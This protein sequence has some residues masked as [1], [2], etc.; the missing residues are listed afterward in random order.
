MRVSVSGGAECIANLPGRKLG[1]QPGKPFHIGTRNV[2]GSAALVKMTP[3]D[4]YRCDARHPLW[5]V[6][7]AASSSGARPIMHDFDVAGIITG[8]HPWFTDVFN[9]AFAPSKS[10]DETEVIAQVQRTRT[11]FGRPELDAAR[12]GFVK[13]KAD[14][15]RLLEAASLDAAGRK[16][17][18]Q[19]LDAFYRAIESDDAFYRPVV[20][21]TDARLYASEN[22]DAVCAARGPAPPGTPVSEPLQTR[23]SLMQVL[24][25]DALWHWAPPAKCPAVREGPVWIETSAVSRNFP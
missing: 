14:A 22:R 15:Y 8:R 1:E 3:D 7:A 5:N 17:A 4:T 10:A 21:A 13:R 16:I 9:A 18:R 12:A 25:L 2:L 20:T 11:L 19:Y 24:V 23:G 6:A